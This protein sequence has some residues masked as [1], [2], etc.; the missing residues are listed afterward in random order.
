MKRYTLSLDFGASNGR[1]ILAAFDGKKIDLTVV[2]RFD[3]TPIERD[4]KIYWDLPALMENCERALQKAYAIAPYESIGIDTWGVDYGMLDKN[5]GLISLPRHYRD[6]R[7]NGYSR[8]IGDV[9]APEAL[10]ARTGTQIMDINTLF[11][12]MAQR[13]E[14]GFDDCRTMLLMPDLIAYLLTGEISAE[15]SIA[16]TTQ[17]VNAETGQWDID[18]LARL[19]IPTHIL[20]PI[21][22]SGTS[23]GALTKEIQKKLSLPPIRVIAVCGHDTQCAAFAAPQKT[24]RRAFLSCGTWSLFGAICDAPILTR[25]AALSEISNETGYDGKT[26]F[27]KNII[28][29]W[30]IQESRRAYARTG[31]K[32]TF[33]EIEK[34]AREAR[35]VAYIDP[36]DPRFTPTGDIPTR[37]VD[38]ARETGQPIPETHG[39]IF[40]TIYESLALTYRQTLAELEACT[41][42]VY[43]VIPLVGGGSQDAFLCE[44]TATACEI[45][46]TAGPIEATIFGNA[47]IQLIALGAITDP[48]D[49]PNIIAS[50]TT[51]TTYP[52]HALDPDKYATFLKV[53]KRQGAS[54]TT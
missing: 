34:M 16:S 9:I 44:L 42:D 49:V 32:Y 41:G 50:S 33:A 38:Y 18:L 53:T 11:Q 30:L 21:V 6:P 25:R 54:A 10:Y 4:G 13:D 26:T 2:H 45:P 52:P 46:T 23:K 3:N 37:I 1:A 8:Q 31:A 12:L 35:C 14:E 43:P 20:P 15:R 24:S 47:M 27:L 28:G 39:E 29:L 36:N 17:M 48:D 19:S 7:T 51:I 40:R 5:G 22:E